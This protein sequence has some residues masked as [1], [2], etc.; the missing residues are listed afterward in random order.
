MESLEQRK[1]QMVL[2]AFY[3]DAFALGPHW[4]Y[5]VDQIRREFGEIKSLTPPPANTYH[6]TKKKGDFTHYGDQLLVLLDSIGAQGTFSQEAYREKWQELFDGY[7]G[8]VDGATKKTL[9]NMS[10]GLE[11]PVGSTSKDLSGAGKIAPLLYCYSDRDQLLEAVKAQV[12][13][14]HNSSPV[15][16]SALFTATL[17]YK[18]LIG[19][20]VATAVSSSL[21][22]LDDDHVKALIEKGVAATGEDSIATLQSFGTACSVEQSLPGTIQILLT[23]AN[24]FAA[25]M[26]ANVMAGGDSAARGLIIGTVLAAAQPVDE[27]LFKEMNEYENI[28]SLLKSITPLS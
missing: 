12:A 10:A 23:H 5:D 3:G 27:A 6:S 1:Q 24:D 26:S 2:G 22:S 25:A 4:I 9:G 21:N 20:S 16:N 14:T 15:I 18:V 17:T 7:S 19:E 8:Y 13:M 11:N 28:L